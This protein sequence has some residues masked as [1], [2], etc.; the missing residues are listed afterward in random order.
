M[1]AVSGRV[2]ASSLL[3]TSALSGKRA[4]PDYF[5]QCEFTK[6]EVLE[7]ELATSEVSGKR[8]RVDEQLR[9]AVSGKTGHKQEFLICHETRQPLTV[10]EAEQCEVTGNYVRPG[11]LEPCA[12]TQKRV[13]PSE[14]ERCAATGKR[15]LKRLLVTSSLIGSAHS[16]RSCRAVG[17]RKILCPGRSQ[18]MS[19]E[20]PQMPSGRSSRLRANRPAHPLRIC[21]REQQSPP[22]TACRPAQW[23]QKNRGRASAVGCRDD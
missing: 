18:T 4:E 22:P 11:I 9:S 10:A 17:N 2:V 21:H 1:S 16:R 12:V 5:G 23:H 19:L 7:T 6:A 20:W 13:L 8:Y 3:K 14:L 15:A